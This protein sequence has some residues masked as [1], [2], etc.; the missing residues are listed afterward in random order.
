MRLRSAAAVL[1]AAAPA[2]AGVPEKGDG[3]IMVL[4]GIRA[5]PGGQYQTETGAKHALFH[6]GFLVGFGFQ[7]DDELHGG[8]QLG[9]AL[10]QYGTGASA[11][12]VRSV[13]V[14]L[15]LDTALWQGNW[16]TVYGGGGLGYSLNTISRSSGDLEANSGL[17]FIA[18]GVRLRISDHLG[19]VVEDRYSVSSA[20]ADPSAANTVNMGGNLLS[21]GFILHF[22]SPEDKG[23]PTAPGG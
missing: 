7:L 2:L 14:L 8:I 23:H 13:Q 12:N 18:L 21:A 10:D 3:T 6:P 9:Y 1:L 22:F 19:F 16:Y 15:A 4:G 5:I 20:A 17:G 11:M